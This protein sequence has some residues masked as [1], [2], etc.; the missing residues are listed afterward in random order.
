MLQYTECL[1]ICSVKQSSYISLILMQ[2]LKCIDTIKDFQ[3]LQQVNDI[4]EWMGFMLILVAKTLYRYENNIFILMLMILWYNFVVLWGTLLFNSRL[5]KCLFIMWLCD[6]RINQGR[7]KYLFYY[8][9][10]NK[11]RQLQLTA[12]VLT[13]FI[14][15]NAVD[16]LRGKWKE[17][18]LHPYEF[19]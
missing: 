12:T 14:D 15:L 5:P 4:R 6:S 11:G 17:R 13:G 2:N 3:A 8:V 10:P 1:K 7:Q 9:Y 19:S 18:N 16:F